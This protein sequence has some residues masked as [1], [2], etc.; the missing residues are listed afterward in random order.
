MSASADRLG[1]ALEEW[2]GLRSVCER[3]LWTG[4]FHE[5]EA[6]AEGIENVDAAEIGEGGI[7]PG[8]K[9]RALASSY[10]L[11]EIVDHECGVG[12]LGGMEVF[13]D[14]K[15]EIHWAG[16]EPDAAAARHGCRL[17]DFGEAEDSSVE[18]TREGFD[19]CGN[20]E[21]H[22]IE[23]K[24]GHRVPTV[25]RVRRQPKAT[26]RSSCRTGQTRETSAWRGGTAL[27]DGEFCASFDVC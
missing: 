13:L 3:A 8:R 2:V 26:R 6:I 17:G 16:R 25:A 11:V 20:R 22:V 24:D 4:A 14:A 27:R 7:R 10:D 9:A 21:L 23:T 19:A 18:A 12:A 1:G 5:F 15:V